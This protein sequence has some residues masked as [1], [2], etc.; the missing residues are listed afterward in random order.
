MSI[1]E[2]KDVLGKLQSLICIHQ[3]IFIND[4]LYANLHVFFFILCTVGDTRS[5]TAAGHN[6]L[7]IL[8]YLLMVS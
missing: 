8:L 7:I 4:K 2:I 1:E 6:A 5:Q 3:F